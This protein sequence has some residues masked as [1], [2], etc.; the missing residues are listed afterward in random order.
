ME[1]NPD[2]FIAGHHETATGEVI[3]W[4]SDITLLDL[5]A[6]MA[7]QGLVAGWRMD[8]DGDPKDNVHKIAED[9]YELASQMLEEREKTLKGETA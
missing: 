3:T 8:A 5:F 1:N 2:L 4:S 6:G 7:M 9:S